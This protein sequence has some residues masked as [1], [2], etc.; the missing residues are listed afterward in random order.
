MIVHR[1]KE[2]LKKYHL[3]AKKKYGQNFLINAHILDK[4]VETSEID[5]TSGV[6]EIGPGIGTLTE[7]L[8]INSKRVLCYEIDKDMIEVLNDTLSN[9]DNIKIICNDFLKVNLKDDIEK[10]LKDCENIIVVANLPYYITTPILFKLMK[11]NIQRMIIMVQKEVGMRLVGKP[12]TK[13]YNALSV[14]MAYKTKSKIF[15]H[16]S[17]NSFFPAP[18]VDSVLLDIKLLKSDSIVNNEGEFL[19]FVETIFMQ[20]RK[21]LVNN[22]ARNFDKEK[23][24]EI[25]S[26]LG[27]EKDI[28]AEQLSLTEIVNIYKTLYE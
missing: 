9:Y 4:I 7:V 5:K 21:T 6:I 3:Q 22:L 28:R 25:L 20:R 15:A 19:K 24:I 17:R 26:T 18:N 8:A 23:I 11:E 13:D 10:Y 12:N 16:V 14:I 2:I 27:Y 1:T